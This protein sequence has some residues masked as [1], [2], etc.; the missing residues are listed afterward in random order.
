MTFAGPYFKHYLYFAKLGSFFVYS[1][2]NIILWFACI[3]KVGSGQDTRSADESGL[4]TPDR[5]GDSHESLC[6]TLNQCL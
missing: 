6:L 5:G 3:N 4:N 1:T 2:Y